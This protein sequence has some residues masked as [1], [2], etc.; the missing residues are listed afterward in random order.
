MTKKST[1]SDL[2]TWELIDMALL[3]YAGSKAALHAR[4][5]ACGVGRV[6]NLVAMECAHHGAPLP[7]ACP[8]DPAVAHDEPMELLALHPPHWER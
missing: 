5:R 8:W 4:M 7:V 6:I 1:I 3:G 2:P